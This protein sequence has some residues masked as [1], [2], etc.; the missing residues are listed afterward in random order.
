MADSPLSHP[1]DLWN[2]WNHRYPPPNPD[3]KTN[4]ESATPTASPNCNQLVGPLR[5]P[6]VPGL[7][8]ELPKTVQQV[9]CGPCLP[10]NTHTQKDKFNMFVCKWIKL[11]PFTVSITFGYRSCFKRMSCTFVQGP[12]PF[13]FSPWRRSFLLL[14]I[15]R[16]QILRPSFPP[17][18]PTA[19]GGK[20]VFFFTFFFFR[21]IMF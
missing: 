10:Q 12:I 19:V 1:K 5:I 14:P 17:K 8:E 2:S 7:V 13:C 20:R 9:I 11:M 21:K 6:S 4:S 16:G 3:H 18:L 15:L